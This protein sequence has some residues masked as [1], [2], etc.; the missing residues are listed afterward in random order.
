MRIFDKKSARNTAGGNGNDDGPPSDDGGESV[1][2]DTAPDAKRPKRRKKMTSRMKAYLQQ[3]RDLA[4]LDFDTE[5]ASEVVVV[6]KKHRFLK[7]H[8]LY[9]S[10]EL[11][12]LDASESIIPNFVNYLPRRDEED[13]EYYCKVMLVLFKS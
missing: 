13:R 8:P 5:D 6:S 11:V 7:E 10:H 2:D 12:Q 9:S 1:D 3:D 4:Y